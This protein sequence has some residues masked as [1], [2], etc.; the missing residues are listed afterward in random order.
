M[1][2]DKADGDRNRRPRFG[3]QQHFE[4]E[5]RQ[6]LSELETNQE[7]IADQQDDIEH[8]QDEILSAVTDLRSDVVTEEE[9][10]ADVL[11][12]V[13]ENQRVRHI[14]RWTA[15]AGGVLASGSVI[16]WGLNMLL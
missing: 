8:K 6:R 7:H 2:G 9:L 11:P 15:R 16:A 3:H 5:T 13:E 14:L 4:T 12:V 10:E 1:T